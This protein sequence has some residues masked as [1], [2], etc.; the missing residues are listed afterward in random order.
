MDKDTR[1]NI[2]E[3]KFKI[4]SAFSEELT[5]FV[6]GILVQDPSKRPTI[7]ALLNH[8]WVVMNVQK[9]RENE[10]ANKN[11]NLSYF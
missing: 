7:D 11:L 6:S 5:D 10:E 8:R 3:M 2:K 4:P 9:Y 1:K